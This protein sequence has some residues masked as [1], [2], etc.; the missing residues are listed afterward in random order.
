MSF[1]NNLEGYNIVK[2]MYNTYWNQEKN[3]FTTSKFCNG[4]LDGKF[5]CWSMGVAL[6]AVGDASIAYPQLAGP[7][8]KP[9]VHAALKYRNKSNGGYSA[10][11][12]GDNENSGDGDVYYDDDAHLLRGL[13]ACYEG[14]KDPEI[15]QIA[16]DLM[17]FMMTG[18]VE[19]QYWKGVKGE[20]WHI[21][22][23][24]IASISNCAA[25]TCALK[26][27]KYENGQNERN[28]LYNFAKACLSFLWDKM[29]D[30]ED[31]L[32]RDGVGMDSEKIDPTK[33]S[34]N[35]GGTL[36][37]ICLIYQIDNDPQWINKAKSLAEAATHRG[38]T[39]F[40]RD[41]SD[42]SKRMWNGPSYFVQLLMEGIVEYLIVFGKVA[43]ES[44]RKCCENEIQRHLSYFR[45]YCFDPNDGLYYISFDI[46][47]LSDEVYKRYKEEFHGHKGF[48]PSNEER[49]GGCDNMPLEKRPMC[50]SLI[51]AGSAARL[52]FQGGRIFPKMDP[53]DEYMHKV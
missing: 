1:D 23:S 41:Y 3:A 42:W 8:V 2:T 31:G 37:A 32:I 24:Y 19:H 34:Y 33:W 30:P 7:I 9:A 28:Q 38:K 14:T 21:S 11:Y 50:K 39:M 29:R 47:K 4:S 40:D 43:P 53:V 20:K 27:W 13:I 35:T 10:F 51:G 48:S 49:L 26:L 12:H 36:T 44:T 52:F 22:K 5:N 46:Y 17:R 15:L 25:A 45:K 18:L 16:K 6:H